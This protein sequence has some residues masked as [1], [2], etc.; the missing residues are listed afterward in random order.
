MA[1]SVVTDRTLVLV[2]YQF[3]YL[4]GEYFIETEM[5][6]LTKAFSRVVVIPMRRAWTWRSLMRREIPSAFVLVDPGG[7][8]L[9]F[10]WRVLTA[11]LD[12]PVLVWRHRHVWIGAGNVPDTSL[13][14]W[15]KSAVKV[16]LARSAIKRC[17]A[18]DSNQLVFYSYWRL[19]AAAALAI[20]KRDGLIRHVFSRAH[21]TDLYGEA[22]HPFENVIHQHASAVFPVSESGLRFLTGFKGFPENN[23]RVQRLGVTMPEHPSRGSDDDVVR[24]VT[25][26]SIIPIKRVSLIAR[27]LSRLP[28]KVEWIHFGDGEQLHLVEREIA[29]FDNRHRAVLKGQVPN[30]VIRDYYRDNPV[31]LFVNLSETEGVPVSIMEALAYGIP[32]IA[33][34][35]GGTAEVVDDSCG[36]LL[37]KEC[38]YD[39]FSHSVD[40]LLAPQQ[41]SSYR[42]AARQ[43]AESVCDAAKNYRQNY[44]LITTIC[45]DSNH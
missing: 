25:C 18:G 26:S 36:Q 41:R 45:D 16:S 21:G 5:K 1:P 37:D 8:P 10:L 9:V 7:T 30:Q 39:S 43:R 2:T 13:W 11:L 22:R 24:I 28:P 19:E 34:D 33:T 38:D 42:R 31:D 6:H 44:A 4:P 20:L 14:S 35:V 17:I 40:R 15:L 12:A 3:P 32:C 29:Q 23:L 27:Y